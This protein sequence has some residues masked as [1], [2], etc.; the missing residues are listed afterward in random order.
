VEAPFPAIPFALG[1]KAG[2]AGWKD[3]HKAVQSGTL[4]ITQTQYDHA[5]YDLKAYAVEQAKRYIRQT[6]EPLNLTPRQNVNLL[7]I[8]VHAYLEGALDEAAK[9]AGQNR[10]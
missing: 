8:Y 3:A 10:A 9:Q 2:A 1:S 4:I 6:I 5:E 7:S